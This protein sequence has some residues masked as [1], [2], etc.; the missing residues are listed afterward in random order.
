MTQETPDGQAAPDGEPASG[1]LLQ[2]EREFRTLAESIPQL[3]WMAHPD[4]HI[5]WYNQRWYEYT[6]TTPEAMEGWGWQA[7]HDPKEL[8]RVLEV[9]R[10]SLETGEPFDLEFPLRGSDGNLRWFLTRVLPIKDASGRILRWFGTNTDVDEQRAAAL[11]LRERQER[12][13][14][15]L[16][17]SGTGTSRWNIAT[18][19]VEWDES[20]CRLF[21]VEPQASVATIEHFLT[22]VHL[23]D[24]PR[25]AAA[26]RQCVE[27]GADFDQE[28]RVMLPDGAVRWLDNKGKTFV[29]AAGVPRYMTGA[30]VDVTE[31]VEREESLR[32][33]A[34]L[35]AFTAQVGIAL[36]GSPTLAAMLDRCCRAVVEHLDAAFA[37]IWTLNTATG[38]LELQA[39]AGLYTSLDGAHAIVPVGRFK[40]GRIAESRTPLVSNDVPNDPNI[41]DPEWARRE[42]MVAFAGFPLMVGDR[43]N[44]VMALFAKHS[45]SEPTLEAMRSVVHSIALG[46]DRWRAEAVRQQFVSLVENSADYIGMATLEGKAIYVNAAGRELVGLPDADAVERTTIPD[47]LTSESW[48]IVR[49]EALPTVLRDGLW[50]GELRFRHRVTDA[51]I[52]MDQTIFLVRDP[53][54]DT[55][56]CLATVGRDLR[57]RIRTE[58]QLRQA[59]QLQAVGTLAGGVAHEVNNQMTAVLGFGAF[60]LRG[61]GLE[62]PQFDDVQHMVKA[63]ERTASIT[64][65][66]LAFSRRQVTRPRDVDLFDVVSELQPV[67]AQLLGADNVL[68][69]V[70]RR[71]IRPVHADP[72]QLEQVL[73]N[74]TANARDAMPAGGTLTI[75]IDDVDLD[76]GYAEAHG[77]I[78]LRPGPFV[79][80]TAVRYR[81]RHGPGDPGPGLRA[82]LYHQAGR[83]GNRTG[84]VHGLWHREA[85][86]GI[87]LGL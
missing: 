13:E 82:I 50:R 60:V 69:L 35:A 27:T 46:L 34:N 18:G 83:A 28:Y 38:M 72:T 62:H 86:P 1:Q 47:Y 43:L 58:H 36:T 44:G 61:L 29:D 49:D 2:R 53:A 79:L 48:P 74:L 8:P 4:G 45:L 81:R 30:C 59:R 37:R 80:L 31:R 70:P 56:L 15:A 51:P 25:V 65:Q 3:T 71:T 42:G 16:F 32:E 64:Q 26:L 63:A 75:S 84:H 54:T 85:A 73:I 20:L 9:W 67:L 76:R 14:A 17:A 68:N 24:R 33:R 11:V 12:L 5:F 77:G 10:R 78:Y 7:V 39:S 66:L 55:P 57:A 22:L 6:G 87:R 40:I 23:D 52:P 19:G 41:R 21:G